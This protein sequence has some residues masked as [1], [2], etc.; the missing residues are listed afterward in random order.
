MD[1]SVIKEFDALDS[2]HGTALEK[3]ELDRCLEEKRLNRALE[4]DFLDYWSINQFRFPSLTLMARDVLTISIS[5]VAS[6][7]AFSIGG[8]ILDQYHS[9]LAHNIVESLICTRDWKFNVPEVHHNYPL[10]ELTQNIMKLDIKD[11]DNTD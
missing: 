2:D 8:R 6:E 9:C 11:K 3:N 5:T 10:E 4:I 7:S 1:A